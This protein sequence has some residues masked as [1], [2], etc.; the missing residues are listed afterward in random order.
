MWQLFLHLPDR[1]LA[2]MGIWLL[3][4]LGFPWLLLRLRRGLNSESKLRK[5]MPPV[6]SLWM[7]AALLTAIELGYALCYD[8]TDA[9]DVT[10]VSHRW[11]S[12]HVD[13]D[14]KPLL[15]REDDGLYYR[16]DL[17]FPTQPAPATHLCFVGDSF[18][19]GHG[20]PNVSDRFTNQLR[21]RI[22]E[23]GEQSSPEESFNVSNLSQPGTDLY[24]TDT[25][26]RNVAEKG[27]GV[28]HFVYVFCLNDIDSCDPGFAQRSSALANLR[29]APD[30]FLV[31]DTYFFN[32]LYFR[33]QLLASPQ[34][35]D[36]Y[37]YVR[38]FYDG[39]A[40]DQFLDLLSGVRD[41]CQEND[42]EFSVVVFPF[43]HNLGPDYPFREI[44]AQIEAGCAELEI[45]CVDLEPVL[46]Q[47]SD[48]NL[49]V[50]PFDAHPNEL[51]HSIVA[52]ELFEKLIVKSSSI[53]QVS[54][55][56]PRQ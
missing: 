30:F 12:V 9:L 39:P 46:N 34:V 54:G 49:T 16:D 56:T 1:Y 17:E 41:A 8:T 45:P 37:G 10:N 15:F 51:A 38:E 50:N 13:S 20:V 48:Q 11:F 55:E 47:H 3:L 36:Y 28:D 19:F 40:W 21:I 33:T 43:L 6:L 14:L 2:G 23:R 29:H 53:R 44:H 32:W 5:L 26:V 24:W 27:W 4:M 35:S 7:V 31:R 25:I 52:D 18:T 22:A 42:V